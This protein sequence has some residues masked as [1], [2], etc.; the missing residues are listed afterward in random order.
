MIVAGTSEALAEFSAIAKEL[1]ARRVLS[2]PVGGAFHTP[3]MSG[4]RDRLRKAV[5][6]TNFHALDPVVVANVDARLHDDPGEAA[7]TVRAAVQPGPLAPE[8]RHTLG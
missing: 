8:P 5:A 7:T 1:G 4:A 2:M 3:L 6:A